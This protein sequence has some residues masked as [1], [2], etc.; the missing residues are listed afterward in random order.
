MFNSPLR[1]IFKNDLYMFLHLLQKM[2]RTPLD[3]LQPEEGSS[4]DRS[5]ARG[6]F[7]QSIIDHFLKDFRSD[8]FTALNNYWVSRTLF[9]LGIIS[10]YFFG[11]LLVGFVLLIDVLLQNPQPIYPRDVLMEGS[12][13]LFSLLRRPPKKVKK[14]E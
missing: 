11:P 3:A 2:E 1:E 6:Y 7:N 5:R 4:Q 9:V 14:S 10:S 13:F 12:K 8:L